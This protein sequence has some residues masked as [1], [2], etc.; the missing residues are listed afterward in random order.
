MIA[1]IH[2]VNPDHGRRFREA[3]MFVRNDPPV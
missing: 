3:L 2:M 1:Y